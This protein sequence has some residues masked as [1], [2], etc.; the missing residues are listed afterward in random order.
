MKAGVLAADSAMTFESLGA[1]IERLDAER[2]FGFDAAEFGEADDP[3]PA[4]TITASS[5]K[6]SAA[7][8]RRMRDLNVGI[9]SGAS[10]PAA[11]AAGPRMRAAG[12]GSPGQRRPA[13]RFRFQTST[14]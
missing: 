9:V 5:G 10:L 14:V 4:S 3:Q 8:M 13:S 7:A 2:G 12:A 1:S 6:E 11:V